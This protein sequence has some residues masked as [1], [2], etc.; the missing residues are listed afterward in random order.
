MVVAV[1]EVAVAVAVFSTS[2]PFNLILVTILLLLVVVELVVG[3]VQLK[4]SKEV[5][6]LDLVKQP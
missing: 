6:L 3:K 5:T 4:D 2:K 1:T